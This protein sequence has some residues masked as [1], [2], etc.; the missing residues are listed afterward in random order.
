MASVALVHVCKQL[1]HVAIR[2]SKVAGLTVKVGF[3]TTEVVLDS[4]T[5]VVEDSAASSASSAWTWL[6]SKAEE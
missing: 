6:R 2:D 5:E 3:S 4:A 1:V